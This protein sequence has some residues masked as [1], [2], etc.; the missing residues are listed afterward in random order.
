MVHFAQNKQSWGTDTCPKIK[1]HI[2]VWKKKNIP[3][4]NIEKILYYYRFLGLHEYRNT[5]P[6]C[7]KE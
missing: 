3:V 2:S 5:K 7:Y 6:E 4:L 1:E